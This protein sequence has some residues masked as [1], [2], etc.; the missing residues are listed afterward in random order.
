MTISS[1][2]S[3]IGLSGTFA[4]GKDTLAKFLVEQFNYFHSST[5]D[6]VR[7]EAMRQFGNNERPTCQI[8]AKKL[9]EEQ[10]A[11]IFVKK[12]LSKF[13]Q[14]SSSA[15]VISGIRTAGEADEIKNAGGIIVFVD[16]SIALRYE[17]MKARQRDNETMLTLEEFKKQEA[18]EWQAGNK[19]SDFN[20]K[21]V[22]E[23]A[24]IVLENNADLD[25]FLQ[26]AMKELCL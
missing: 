24:D 14:S 1:K 9:R 13:E 7:E 17:R 15:V 20:L 5:G 16:A 12:A 2:P 3:I 21:L 8:V 19:P 18:K 26:N 6:M 23:M 11:G 4:G 10:G 22:K 25:S